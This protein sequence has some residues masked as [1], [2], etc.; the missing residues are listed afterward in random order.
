MYIPGCVFGKGHGMKTINF[1]R[2]A[3]I[4][5]DDFRKRALD[6]TLTN[7]EKVGY[8]NEYRQGLETVIFADIRQKI[9]NLGNPGKT[10]L[11]IGPGCSGPARMMVELCRQQGHRLIQVDS[12][13]MLAHLPDEEFVVKISGRFPT[14]CDKLFQQ[15]TGQVDC[16]LAYSVL[17][18]IFVDQSVFDFV[19]QALS[20]L[21]DK[22]Q[23]LMGDISNSSKR[24]R[25]FSSPSGIRFHQEFMETQETIKVNFNVL[26]PGKI[27]DAVI[28]SILMRCRSAG[29]DAYVLPQ[30]DNL[31]MANRREDILIVKP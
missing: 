22:G 25:F 20:L 17:Q 14:E 31:P 11:D 12:A 28:L 16:I 19:D 24:K 8:P 29:Y 27:D 6:D 18:C 4:G 9:T 10:V 15:Y 3:A 1:E 26:E 7:I 5:Y 21:R 23:F 30:P 13:E 2:F